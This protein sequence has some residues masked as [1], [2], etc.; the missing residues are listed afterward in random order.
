MSPPSDR[1]RPLP[2]KASMMTSDIQCPSVELIESIKRRWADEKRYVVQEESIRLLFHEKFPRHD[3]LAEVLIKVT[4]L[5]DFYSTVIYFPYAVAQRIV[6]LNPAERIKAGDLSLV[7][8]MKAVKTRTGT[9]KFYSFTTKYCSQHNP[10]AFPIY[11]ARVREM[12]MHFRK[13]DQFDKFNKADLL[14]YPCFVD[15]LKSFRKFYGLEPVPWRWIDRFLWFI[16]TDAKN[17][18]MSV[19]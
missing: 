12:L 14:E 7:D 6:E 18:A 13:V 8:E 19:A 4:V 17:R 11:D 3:N 16:G 2:S 10:E 1:S 15:V 9:K 5:K